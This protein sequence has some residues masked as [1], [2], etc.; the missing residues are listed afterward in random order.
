MYIVTSQMLLGA[1]FAVYS[2]QVVLKKQHWLWA[3]CI[4]GL[5]F[6][7]IYTAMY[8][9]KLVNITTFVVIRNNTV[10][11]TPI[12]SFIDDFDA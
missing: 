10:V 6:I 2:C 5:I 12:T 4:P 11:A 9:L 7:M 3:T 1:I 8:G